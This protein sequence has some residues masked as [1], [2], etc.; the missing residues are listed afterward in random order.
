VWVE[1]PEEARRLAA[2]DEASFLIELS[3]RLQGLLGR[4]EDAGPRA[5]YPLSGLH[6]E[7]MGQRR[8][9]LV[10]EAAHVIPPIGAQG[11][12]LGLRDAA[13]LADCVAA[14]RTQGDDIGG[15]AMLR[16]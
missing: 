1:A 11:L 12:N 13:T 9:A 14:A 7:C 10:G 16:A 3:R 2:L 5:A 6:A 15:E 8:I 4:L